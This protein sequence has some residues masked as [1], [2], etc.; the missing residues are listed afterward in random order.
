MKTLV[1]LVGLVLVLEGLPYLAFP[2]TMQ[3]W[4]KQLSESRPVVIRVVG[5]FAVGLGLLLCYLARKTGLFD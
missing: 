5:G 2:E 1:S 4:L 3:N